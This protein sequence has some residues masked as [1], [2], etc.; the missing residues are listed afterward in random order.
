MFRTFIF[1]KD[2]TIMSYFKITCNINIITNPI[3]SRVFIIIIIL[4]NLHHLLLHNSQNI[5]SLVIL[6]ILFRMGGGKKAPYQFFQCNF[7]KR[8]N[9]LP[10]LSYFQFQPFAT[11]L[12]NFKAIPSLNLK[13]LNLNQE[14]PSKKLIFWSNPS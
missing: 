8:R 2:T 12:Q 11:L 14:H 4:S 9:Q 3:F 6:L 1:S 13:L 10:K 7:Y 5:L